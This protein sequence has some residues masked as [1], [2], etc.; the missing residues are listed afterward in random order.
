MRLEICSAI[1]L[2]LLTCFEVSFLELPILPNRLTK[3]K[4]TLH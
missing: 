3:E 2:R 4:Q 1:S